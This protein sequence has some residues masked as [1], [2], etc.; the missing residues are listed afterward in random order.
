MNTDTNSNTPIPIDKEVSLNNI[1]W[2]YEE[3]KMKL[4]SITRD[5]RENIV[6]MF[7]EINLQKISAYQLNNMIKY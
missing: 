7:K 4:D 6:N 5:E 3:I 1:L 2:Y